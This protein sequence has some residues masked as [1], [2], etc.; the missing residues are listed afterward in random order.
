MNIE[1]SKV[2][3]ASQRGE[4]SSLCNEIREGFAQNRCHL[5]GLVKILRDDIRML[6]DRV[7]V[8]NTKLDSFQR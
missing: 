1:T 4:C 2:M 8:V 6:A 3:D 5:E 7:A